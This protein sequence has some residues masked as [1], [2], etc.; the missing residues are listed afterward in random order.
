MKAR[1]FLF[2]RV[3]SNPSPGR[4]RALRSVGY[5]FTLTINPLTFSF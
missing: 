1:E 4:E 2:L 3:Y 5:F